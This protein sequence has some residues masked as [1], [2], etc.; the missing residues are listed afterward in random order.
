MKTE[1]M[2][3]RTFHKTAAAAILVGGAVVLFLIYLLEPGGRGPGSIFPQCLFYKLTG[4][5][6]PGC[7]STR[8]I[9]AILHGDILRAF[10]YNIFVVLLLPLL[11]AGGL[12]FT[13]EMIHGRPLF[14]VRVHPLLIWGLVVA[15]VAFWI[16]RNL[17]FEPF[18]LL[19]P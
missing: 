13:W 12:N 2:T 3:P 8:A 15:V 17:P 18:T 14:R 6:C 11:A 16:L 19:A 9:H 7:G 5:Y 4:L 1:S 10:G